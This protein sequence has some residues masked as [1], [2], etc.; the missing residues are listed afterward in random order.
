MV[1]DAKPAI[2]M[3]HDNTIVARLI[4]HQ[5]ARE[6]ARENAM[7]LFCIGQDEQRLISQPSHNLAAIANS[8][9]LA[10]VI[11]TS[12]STG[13]PKG[14]QLTHGGLINYL[15]WC[16]KA[17]PVHAG[18]GAP[19]ASSIG[20]DATIT[21][22]F[23]PLLAGKQ[24]V[25]GL[26]NS[27]DSAEIEALIAALSGGFS[28]I[29]LTPAHLSALR[30]L[31]AKQYMQ[32]AD[33]Q[34]IDTQQIDRDRLPKAFIIGGESLRSQH[35]SFWRKHY[36]EIT[37]INEYGPTE[38]VVG[39]C[40]HWV[41]NTDTDEGNIPIGRPIDGTQLYILDEHQQPVPVGVP[42][43]LYVGGAGVA[44]GYLNQPALTT[45]RFITPPPF[46][47]KSLAKYLSFPSDISSSRLYKT[48]DLATYLPNGTLKYLG[49][50]DDQIKLRGFRIEPGEIEAALCQ[51]EPV[52]QALVVLYEDQNRR[53]LVAYLTAATEA[54]QEENKVV[55]LADELRK[56]LRQSL[57]SYMVPAHF[58][59]LEALPLTSHGKIDRQALPS[60]PTAVSIA[61]SS[62]PRDRKEAVLTEIWQQIL[63]RSE[64][65]IY[66]NF[67]DL[68]G[69][70][71]S[72]MQIVSKA[73]QHGL[74]LTP[75]QLFSIPNDCRTSSCC[76]STAVD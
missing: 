33:T 66:D 60:P 40:V 69:D 51:C 13:K 5:N 10:Y 72:A 11:Y 41:T 27:K 56:Q 17:Y 24:V 57:P 42:G 75:T 35:I 58:V 63:N 52:E 47:A 4:Q 64:V 36:P 32:Q 30:P 3:G 59:W 31:V 2:L 14:T 76:H 37:L 6:N 61:Q 70:S 54:G 28:F 73:H 55:Q 53:E 39:C 23:S 21:S 7:T 71:I 67:F 49:R 15:D 26:G 25:F 8:T 19:V 65:S 38:A 44:R 20:F 29:K 45:D 74:H 62:Q 50:I 1:R 18:C 9:N 43:E 22:L 48:G 16:L 46:L 68:G 12:G 34:Q